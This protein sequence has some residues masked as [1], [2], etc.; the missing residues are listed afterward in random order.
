[1]LRLFHL[2]PLLAWFAFV[3]DSQ[4]LSID[5]KPHR[6]V[7]TSSFTGMSSCAKNGTL[8][9]FSGFEIEVGRTNH[10]VANAE[11]ICAAVQAGGQRIMANGAQR[12]GSGQLVRGTCF[13]S[14]SAT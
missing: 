13:L 14:F 1:M 9:D 6:N 2:L 10:V 8:S 3:A 5:S 4:A 11:D 7:C 12:M